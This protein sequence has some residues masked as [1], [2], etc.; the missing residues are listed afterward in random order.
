MP[1]LQKYFATIVS[2]TYE[3]WEVLDRVMVVEMEHA[4]AEE[5]AYDK[6]DVC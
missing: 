1:H 2:G 5:I 3:V 4:N 6:I